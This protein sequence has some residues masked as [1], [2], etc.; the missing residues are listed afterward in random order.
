[1]TYR[2]WMRKLDNIINSQVGISIYD[3]P[4]FCSRDLFDS[5]C[6]PE[7]GAEEALVNADFPEDL[8]AELF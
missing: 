6:S 3:L 5:G 1:M 2:E 7:E 4:D 8:L